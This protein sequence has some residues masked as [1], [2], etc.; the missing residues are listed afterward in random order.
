M[1]DRF[2]N[3]VVWDEL[4][5]SDA[6]CGSMAA[7]EKGLLAPCARCGSHVLIKAHEGED[8][9][10]RLCEWCE[11]RTTGGRGDA[12]TGRHGEERGSL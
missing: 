2:G 6:W 11:G 12:E 9:T 4:A 3:E 5:W 1:M 7:A 10:G 8:M